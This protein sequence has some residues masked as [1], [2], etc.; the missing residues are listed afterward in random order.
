VPHQ[1]RFT[2]L[3]PSSPVISRRQAV[4][5]H[6][7]RERPRRKRDPA[8]TRARSW[9][10]IDRQ[11]DHAT[12]SAI[13]TNASAT[14]PHRPTVPKDARREGGSIRRLSAP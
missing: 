2:L 10:N 7:G 11:S 12:A 4:K 13:T 1:S 6:H 8:R 14:P 3:N 5:D 9:P